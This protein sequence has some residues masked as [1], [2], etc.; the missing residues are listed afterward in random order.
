MRNNNKKTRIIIFIIILIVLILIDLV[1]YSKFL[2]NE[3][4]DYVDDFSEYDYSLEEEKIKPKDGKIEIIQTV[5]GTGNNLE[6]VTIEFDKDFRTYNESPIEIKI[7]EHDSR[8][9]NW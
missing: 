7:V 5:I 4:N 2:Y 3:R 1:I 9:Y 8:K 6:A